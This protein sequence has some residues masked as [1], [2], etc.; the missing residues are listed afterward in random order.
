MI[1]PEKL[2]HWLVLLATVPLASSVVGCASEVCT[3]EWR[4]LERAIPPRSAP[5]SHADAGTGG[6]SAADAAREAQGDAG[7]DDHKVDV[8]ARAAPVDGGSCI[9]QDAGTVDEWLA[10]PC[11][12]AC[13]RL[14]PARELVRCE[15]DAPSKERS[16][17]VRCH[18]RSHACHEPRFMMGRPAGGFV[19]KTRIG[20]DRASYFEHLAE[21]EAASVPAFLELAR[22][23]E[24]LGFPVEDVALA[25]RSAHDERRHARAMRRLA[26]RAGSARSSVREA[27]VCAAEVPARSPMTLAV[28]ACANATEGCVGELFA[29]A[30]ATW[31]AANATDEVERRAFERIA[32]DETRH[33]ALALRLH[34]ALMSRLDVAARAEVEHAKRLAERALL[35][36]LAECPALVRLGL[37]PPIERQ[38]ALFAALF[39]GALD[40]NDGAL[41]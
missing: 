8:L 21:I 26:A 18:V 39:G 37:V 3:T 22:D 20:G 23:L 12:E 24:R 25:R 41:S 10:L 27:P 19:P 5:C 36:G 11:E 4:T 31:I 15:S 38:R 13:A 2:R 32:S 16:A 28:L 29:A 35:E 7:T 14:F 1:S 17:H 40:D 30:V 6:D 34:D 9:E 33:A